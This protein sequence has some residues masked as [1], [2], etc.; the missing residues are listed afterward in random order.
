MDEH[1]RPVQVERHSEGGTY[2]IGGTTD[3]SLNV[4]YNYAKFFRDTID[5]DEGIRWI[6]NKTGEECIS[7]LHSAIREL[8]TVQDDNYWKATE[9]NAGHA[10]SIL[11]L[12]AKQ[13]PNA[14]FRGD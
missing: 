12:W 11:M 3:A 2:E 5:E 10:L 13:Y 6:V 9:G 4:T 7:K 14:V 1:N 8:G